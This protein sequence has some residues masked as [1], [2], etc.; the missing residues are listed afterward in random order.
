MRIGIDIG[1]TFTDFVLFDETS[2]QF[3][4]YKLLSTPA[5][6]EKA[7]LAGLRD[8]SDLRSL[9][10]D[11]RIIHGSTVATN[12]LLERKGARTAFVTTRGFKDI[13]TIGRQNRSAE[14]LYD[15]FADRPPPLIPPDLCFEIGERVDHEGRVLTPLAES[16]LPDLVGR[17]QAAGVESAAI[18]LLFSFLHPEH[19]QR[20]AAALARAGLFVSA[21]S[22]IL[23]EFREYERA[24]TTAINAFVSPVM[25]RYI[26]RLVERLPTRDFRIMQSNG[27]MI[28]AETARTQAVRCIL[29][30]PAGGAVGALYVAKTAGFERIMA[31]DMGGTSTE[32]SLLDG[33]LRVTSE[34]EIG[35]LPIRIPI[36]DIHTVGAGGGSIASV[37]AGGALRVGPQ[38]AGADP[39]PACYGRGGREATVTDANLVLGRLSPEHFLAGEMALDVRAAE[40]ALT[41]LARQ[42]PLTPSPPLSPA[43]T[44][45]LGV[46]QIANAHMERA[47]RVISVERGYDPADF[48]LVSFGGAG[49]LHACDLARGLGMKRVLIPPQAAVLSALGM[50]AADVVKDYVQTVML[51]GDVA[52]ADL[53]KRFAPLLVRG[54]SDLQT[55]GFAPDEIQQHRQLDMRYRGQ[56]FELTIPLTPDF[57]ADFHAEH[58]RAYGHA[59]PSAPVEIVNIRVRA[60]GRVAP[61]PLPSAPP[62]APDP[63]PALLGHRPVAL[64]WGRL[65]ETSFYDGAK[66][67]PGHDISGPAVIVGKNTTIYL[68]GSDKARVDAHFNLIVELE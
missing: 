36:I 56:S 41:E 42:A 26:G 9:T 22:D 16:E 34:A 6:P 39:G 58:R 15:F 35:G 32:V 27:G 66:L 54:E 65:A 62:G 47:L 23:P 57:L 53:E 49:G 3:H 51:A 4:T 17:L 29:S 46:I 45:A 68:G 44:A 7:V 5:A 11:L 25:D 2:G 40:A 37:D 33:D 28:G 21:S 52:Y 61:P 63:T 50:L 31:F 13:L 8:N 20:I 30:G 1:G 59:E 12:A 19:E 64:A 14:A 60:L 18:C 38:S 24:S 67:R 10:S 55:E 48:T 43:Q